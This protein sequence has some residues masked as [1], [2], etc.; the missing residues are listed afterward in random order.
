VEELTVISEFQQIE[1]RDVWMHELPM[2][3]TPKRRKDLRRRSEGSLTV[4]FPWNGHGHMGV[5]H[6]P[7]SQEDKREW[8]DPMTS[9]KVT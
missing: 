9:L 5:Y 3:K 8:W 2:P 4:G 1:I 6:V 7:V